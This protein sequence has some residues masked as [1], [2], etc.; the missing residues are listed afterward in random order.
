LTWKSILLVFVGA[1]A[2]TWLAAV[3]GSRTGFDPVSVPWT[4]A[5]VCVVVSVVVLWLAWGVRQYVAGKRP[6]LD[7]IKAAR[8]VVL[9]QA[10][11]YTGA[12]L[13]GGFVG[14][15]IAMAAYWDHEPRREVVVAA[16]IAA[17]G[18]LVLMGAGWLG[19]RWCKVDPEDSD[20]PAA[21]GG[22]LAT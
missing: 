12:M 16:G 5:V 14:Y 21:P 18:A 15:A 1:G 4:T 7:P 8:T 10:S 3:L 6:D 9:A 22:T 19:E 17:V 11:A 2:L 13:A 20:G